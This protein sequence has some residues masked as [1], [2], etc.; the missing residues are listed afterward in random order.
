VKILNEPAIR[1]ELLQHGLEPRPGTREELAQFIRKESETWGKVI[2][3]A[4]ITA[5]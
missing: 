5:E 1:D 3:D 2:R 4:K